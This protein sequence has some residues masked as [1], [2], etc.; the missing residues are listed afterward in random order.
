MN[1]SLIQTIFIFISSILALISP[2]VYAKAI[3]KGEAKPHRTTRFI[4]LVITTLST[5]SLL[6]N[7][8]TVAVWLAAISTIQA[9][10]VFLLSLKYG[11]GGWAK[12]DILCL[13]IA[14]IGIIFWQT[15]NNPL[16]GLYFSIL[17]DLTGMI[18]TIIKTYQL[19]QTEIAT[20]F[21]L[22][23]IASIFTFFANSD[24]SVANI[25]YPVYL[26]LINALMVTLII[27]PKLKHTY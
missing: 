12:I 3:L 24:F 20:F 18:P 13:V 16:F 7:H 5:A 27:T 6:A 22:D 8:N 21:A 2:I 17:A 4:L 19:P 26:M 14:I 9:I 25:A 10:I 1:W 23:T 15:T 11:M